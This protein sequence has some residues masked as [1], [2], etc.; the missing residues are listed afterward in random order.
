MSHKHETIIR[1]V[2]DVHRKGDEVTAT[3]LHDPT[4]E[5]LDVAP[6]MDGSASMEDGYGPRGVLAK[7]GGVRNLVEPQMQWMLEY[8]A[9][10]DRN[11]VLRTAYW[12]TSDGSAIEVV[13]ELDGAKAKEYKFPGPKYYGKATVMLPVLRDY[14]AYIREAV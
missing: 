5:G 14:V 6:Y 4:V 3:L 12:A 7:L 13:G 11:G 9:S 8:L 1:P 2:S 10:K